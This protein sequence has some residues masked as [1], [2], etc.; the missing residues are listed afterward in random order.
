MFELDCVNTF[1]DISRKQQFSVILATRGPTWPKSGSILNTLLI[2]VHHK[3][4]LD[5]MNTF[6]D[7]GPKPTF[8]PIVSNFLAK[9]EPKLG[10][11]GPKANQFWT[12]TQQMH[13]PNLKLLE[14]LLFQIMVGNRGW[15]GGRMDRR[16]PFI[17]PLPTPLAGTKSLRKATQ[18]PI[19]LTQHKQ[20]S[21][22]KLPMIF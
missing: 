7:N 20:L 15:T 21:K 11:H 6:W 9:R 17:C 8:W 22:R 4:E 12:L 2:S 19:P 16:S 5:C 1:S 10:L 3:F 14:W 18:E 13:T